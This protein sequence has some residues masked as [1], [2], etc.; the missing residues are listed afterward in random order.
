MGR[1]TNHGTDSITY[2]ANSN[3]L[4]RGSDTYS[5]NTQ[6][7]LTESIYQD[8][9][10]GSGMYGNAYTYDLMGNRQTAENIRRSIR[11]TRTGAT[12]LVTRKKVWGYS[13]NTLNQYSDILAQSGTSLISITPLSSPGSTA[14]LTGITN[15]G[16][17]N[18]GTITPPTSSTGEITST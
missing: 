16:A 11:T 6:N 5:Y 15:T 8:N 17:T 18:T 10:F 12:L 14:T 9:R 1:I 13:V 3:I 2:D 7:E 4:S